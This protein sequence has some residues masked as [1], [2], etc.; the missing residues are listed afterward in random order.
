MKEKT[1]KRNSEKISWENLEIALATDVVSRTKR[2]SRKWFILW[3]LTAVL[4]VISNVLW[5]IAY[6][7]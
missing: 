2:E 1:T 4:L 3:V 7:M 5:Y 6:T